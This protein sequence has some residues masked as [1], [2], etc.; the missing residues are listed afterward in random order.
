MTT[1]VWCCHLTCEYRARLHSD[2][3]IVISLTTYYSNSHALGSDDATILF[4]AVHKFNAEWKPFRAVMGAVARSH[5]APGRM[6]GSHCC[7][8][9]CET[10]T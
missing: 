10:K 9:R 7:Y 2:I 3:V 1:F 8:S 5:S 4:M 6:R